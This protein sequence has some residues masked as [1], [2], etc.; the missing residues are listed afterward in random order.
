MPLTMRIKFN[1]ADAVL[2]NFCVVAFLG[3]VLRSKILFPIPFLDYN[4]LLDAHFH[5]AFAGWVTLSLALF[6][7][8]ILPPQQGIKA[9]YKR[10][11]VYILAAACLLL[12]SSPLPANSITANLC[13]M[14]FILVTYF[15]AWVFISGILKANASATEK[16]L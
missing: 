5:F 16:L 10:V 9:N 12:C 11:L 15:F 2:F 13:F 7:Q 6:M 14:V 4:R 8:E 1:W 3:F